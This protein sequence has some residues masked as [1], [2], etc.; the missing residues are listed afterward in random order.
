[1]AHEKCSQRFARRSREANPWGTNLKAG[2]KYKNDCREGRCTFRG[3]V[4]T[5]EGNTLLGK[6]SLKWVDVITML[7]YGW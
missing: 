4:G 5:A 2:G 3:L 1:M 7:L 6:P